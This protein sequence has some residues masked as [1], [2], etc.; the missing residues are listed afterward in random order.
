MSP[1]TPLAYLHTAAI[2]DKQHFETPRNPPD[3]KRI[4]TSA[5]HL[6]KQMRERLAD[7]QRFAAVLQVQARVA[8]GVT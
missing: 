1:I 7:L 8:A 6:P 4:S 5:S 3:A 2:F